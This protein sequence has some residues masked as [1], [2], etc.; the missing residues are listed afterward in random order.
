MP[1]KNIFCTTYKDMEFLGRFAKNVLSFPAMSKY[2]DAD[3]LAQPLKYLE[4]SRELHVRL[5]VLDAGDIGLLRAYLR[6]Q[7]LLRQT[8]LT[9]FLL[10]PL[11]Q[12]KCLRP[13]SSVP[14]T[15][16]SS[17]IISSISVHPSAFNSLSVIFMYFIFLTVVLTHYPHSSFNLFSRCLL[18]LF[19]K[20][21]QQY[22]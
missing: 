4:E 10:Q 9:A 8:G 19:L 15:P 13:R 14:E 2:G 11:R 16:K 12:D 6:R 18:C 5:S 17:E 3:P 1:S 7:L 21:T 22:H 20:S